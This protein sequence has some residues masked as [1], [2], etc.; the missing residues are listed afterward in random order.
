MK[1]LMKEKLTK[2]KL[3]RETIKFTPSS[4]NIFADLG[5][6]DPEEYQLKTRLARLINKIVDERG[7]TQAETAK[8][9]GIKQPHVSELSRGLLDHFSVERLLHF[10]GQLGHGVTITVSHNRVP[11]E[12]IILAQP[13]VKK[14]TAKVLNARV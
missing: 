14:Q 5:I 2:K 8:A 6:E 9:L 3:T 7:W 11:V 12:E 1:K 10:L 13:K 4:G